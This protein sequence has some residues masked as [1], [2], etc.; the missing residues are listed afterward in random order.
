MMRGMTPTSPATKSKVRALPS[1]AKT[2]TRA[3]PRMK[4]DH[5]SAFGGQ[6]ISRMAPGS[7]SR[8]AAATVLEI[9]KLVL[10]VM[11]TRPPVAFFGSWASILCVNCSL[12]FL[13][14]GGVSSLIGPGIEPWN[15]YFS[16]SG[17]FLKVSGGRRKFSAM[18]DTGVRASQS[19]RMKVLSSE[20]LPSSKTRRNSVPL[21]LRPCSECGWPDGKY[22]RSPFS[23][24]SMKDPPS[25]SSAVT[26]TLPSRT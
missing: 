23:K 10:S 3:R 14:F 16:F 13:K 22:Q 21:G 9:G 1:A 5:S 4:K 18:T 24:S 12:D 19:V 7:I 6:C 26:R 20:K 11:R 8:C 25:V 15:M 2:V 17:R